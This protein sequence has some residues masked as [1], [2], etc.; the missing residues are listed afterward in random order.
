MKFKFL[1]KNSVIGFL[2]GAVISASVIA[3]GL[4]AY[5]QKQI[6]EMN[7][8]AG[9]IRLSPPEIPVETRVDLNWNLRTL[10]RLY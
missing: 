10:K 8:P 7:M 9:S 1:N 4:Y 5:I 6:N 3:A 2:I